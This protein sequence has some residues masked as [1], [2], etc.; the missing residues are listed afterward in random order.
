MA[1]RRK[2]SPPLAIFW[3]RRDQ[4]RFIDAVERLVGLVGDLKVLLEEKKR[5]RRARKPV[6]VVITGP[7]P[8][9]AEREQVQF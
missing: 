8:G 2:T 9:A 7:C 6:E 3:T 1:R 5:T 4:R